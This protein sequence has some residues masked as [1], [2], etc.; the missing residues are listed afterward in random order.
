HLVPVANV[1]F[2]E[3][4]VA[5]AV[6][7]E[8]VRGRFDDDVVERNFALIPELLV[9]GIARL[10]RPLH[11]HFGGEKEVGDGAE[12]RR[13]ALGDGLADLGERYVLVRLPSPRHYGG[14]GN[15]DRSLSLDA[16]IGASR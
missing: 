4:G 15:R 8:G 2:L 5:G 3:P 13:Q 12:R 7:R 6:L 10:A 16:G 11:V 14:P 1:V 9:Q